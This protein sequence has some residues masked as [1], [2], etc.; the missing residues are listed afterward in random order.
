MMLTKNPTV[1]DVKSEIGTYV[2]NKPQKELI[3]NQRSGNKNV[4]FV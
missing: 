2:A 4:Q 1:Q 3:K